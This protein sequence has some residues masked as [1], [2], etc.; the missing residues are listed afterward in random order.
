M[1][2]KLSFLL[3]WSS[4]AAT[5]HKWKI[6][7]A[8]ARQQPAGWWNWGN[9][10]P[11]WGLRFI[12]RL[13]RLVLAP[14]FNHSLVISCPSK[15]KD[16]NSGWVGL[17]CSQTAVW[18]GAVLVSLGFLVHMLRL[19]NDQLVHLVTWV[20]NQLLSINNRVEQHSGFHGWDLTYRDF[21][22]VSKTCLLGEWW[23]CW[24]LM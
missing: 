16:L 18:Q 8:G 11:R 2:V 14:L 3:R 20:Q 1:S 17:L 13:K 12:H 9:P 10:G 7:N 24:P 15:T 22:R 4:I 21:P 5:N 19:G 6:C 23:G